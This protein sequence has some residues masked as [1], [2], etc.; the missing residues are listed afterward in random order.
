VINIIA[1]LEVKNREEFNKFE[2]Q[3]IQIIRSHGGKLVAAFEPDTSSSSDSDGIEVHYIQF[4]DLDKY[5]S[6]RADPALAVLS[7][8][9]SRAIRS[10]QLYVSDKVKA[11]SNRRR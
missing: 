6:Y 3:A 2:T 4:P 7:Q 1:I 5:N 8:L 11:I 9:R 10:T